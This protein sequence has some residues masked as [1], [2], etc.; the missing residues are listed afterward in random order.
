MASSRKSPPTEADAL[1]RHFSARAGADLAAATQVA[2]G[3]S[4]GLDSSVL[5]HL[6][7]CLR[8]ERPFVLSAFHLHHGLSPHADDWLAH[9]AAVCE[10]LGVPFS[11]RRADLDA[12]AGDSLEARARAA[13][14][15]AYAALGVDRVALA[16]HRD[17]QAETVLYRLARG[18]G[19]HGAAAMPALRPLGLSRVWRPLLDVPRAD[20]L[21]YAQQHGLGWVED[22]SNRSIEYDRNYLRRRVLPELE[23]RFPA[24]PAALARAARHFGE[25]AQLLDELAELDA[26]GWSPRLALACFEPL[27]P[28]RRR[29][30]L[31]AFL[32]R[33]GL[34]PDERQLALLLEQMLEARADANPC[35]RLGGIAVHRYRGELWLGEARPL[36]PGPQGLSDAESA[37]LPGWG[38]VLTW[39]PASFGL[40]AEGRKALE[41][42]PRAGGESIRLRRGGPRRP[43]KHLLQEAGVPPWLRDRWPLL[44]QGDRL[45]A[46]AG[47]A[48]AAECQVEAGWRPE[49][50]P[51]DWPDAPA[52]LLPGPAR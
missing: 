38:G 10:R 31:R 48:V 37:P 12:A 26:G 5:L 32:A 43:V 14:Y 49:W 19:V 46:V 9:C 29:N 39:C 4:G 1:Y 15:A 50:R 42:R 17:D 7:A 2:V 30:L 27:T 16:H 24:A 22:E 18:A 44:W 34:R 51:D 3:F 28:A 21:A 20:L 47:L 36:P 6:L 33:A 41:L 45:V 40:A 23:A 8:D 35:F 11:W 52:W 13:R 25:A